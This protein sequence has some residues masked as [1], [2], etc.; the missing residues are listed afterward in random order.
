MNKYQI[1]NDNNRKWWILSAL[2]LMVL[3]FNIDITALNIALPAIARDFQASMS[4]LQWVLNSYI[5]ATAMFTMVGGKLG[6]MFGHRKIFVFG[7][8]IFALASL[9]CGISINEKLLIANRAF[10]GI[11]GALA[12]PMIGVIVFAA[13]PPKQ[14]GLAMGI[15]GGTAGLTQSIG[16]TLGGTIVKYLGW[17]WIFFVNVPVSIICIF[18]TIISCPKYI[19]AT[20]K[21][22]IDYKGIVLLSLGLFLLTY[23]INEVQNWGFTSSL[24]LAFLFGSFCFLA[25]FTYFAKRMSSTLV[26]IKLFT[27]KNFLAI[28]FLRFVS[29]F[30]FNVVFFIF[31]LCLQNILLYDPIKT[32][33]LMLFMTGVFGFLA[34]IGGR[35]V[36]KF[37]PRGPL[38][39]AFASLGISFILFSAIRYNQNLVLLVI[40]LF[41]LGFSVGIIFPATNISVLNVVSDKQ[42]GSANG[43]YTT[44]TM[45]SSAFGIAVSG[46]LVVILSNN[47]LIKQ[48]IAHHFN[49]DIVKMNLLQQISRGIYSI[50]KINANFSFNAI[51]DLIR[52]AREA[53]L[54]SFY[55][56][57]LLCALLSFTGFMVLFYMK[58]GFRCLNK[59]NKGD[60]GI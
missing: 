44:L 33:L 5:L 20:H 36:D 31:V 34:P 19:I 9:L 54:Y 38:M 32:G 49:F 41:L 26:D 48:L 18:L 30:G 10:Q 3:M 60:F 58:N 53:F 11:G 42:R 2:S 17:H 16:P 45:L 14:K 4:S 39:L 52:I 22:K 6:D 25:V 29:I 27:N 1:I 21:E 37:G 55:Y 24:F 8:I 50:D 35:I 40:A 47:Y 12:F 43:I 15:F 46:G 51:G 28:N 23:A 59:E 57:M 13:F 7:V 56:V